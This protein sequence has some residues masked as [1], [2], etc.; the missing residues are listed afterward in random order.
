MSKNSGYNPMDF[1]ELIERSSLGTP[2]AKAIRARTPRW[3]VDQVVA[4]HRAL[5]A[6]VTLQVVGW[7]E[8]SMAMPLDTPQR[9]LA[10]WSMINRPIVQHALAGEMPAAP[11]NAPGIITEARVRIQLAA[12]EH[13][14][15]LLPEP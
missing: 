15:G 7:A 9:V 3:A 6:G 1:R 11:E 8:L 5:E 12:I 13:G 4:R 2:A 14:M 10:A